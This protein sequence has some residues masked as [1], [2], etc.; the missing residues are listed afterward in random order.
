MIDCSKAENYF[1]E[2]LR[3]T[4]KQ[5]LSDSTY[6]CEI[7]C[8]DC[9]LSRLNNGMNIQCSNL[10]KSYP[11]KAVA[12]MQKWS[13]EHP[14]KTYLSEFLKNYPNVMLN[15]DG[16][17]ADVCLYRL[18]LINADECAEN[19]SCIECWNQP[20]VDNEKSKESEEN[21]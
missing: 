8:G 3:L 10:E 17:P 11:S 1:A 2:K 16:L 7:T 21:D 14:P 13:D 19:H 15:S 9:P 12:I 20:I 4:G 5:K 18:G 6:I